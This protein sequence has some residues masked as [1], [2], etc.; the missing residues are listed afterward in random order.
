MGGSLAPF[1]STEGEM[2]I[3]EGWK[4]GSKQSTKTM[5]Y[6][7]YISLLD[8]VGYCIEKTVR[9]EQEKEKPND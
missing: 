8:F 7:E 6:V 4:E 1:P 3:F 5:N 2:T 9:L